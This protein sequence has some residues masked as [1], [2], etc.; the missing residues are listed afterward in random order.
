MN[1]QRAT[2]EDADA[3]TAIAFAAKRHW[4]YP[5]DWIQRWKE[6]L[7]I[8]PEFVRFHPTYVAIE[9]QRIVGFCAFQLRSDAAFLEHLWVE[10]GSIGR[11]VGRALFDC[12]EQLARNGG[13]GRIEIESD[14]NAKG[15]YEQMGATVYGAE[16]AAMEDYPR[17]LPLLRKTLR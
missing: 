1:V 12:V 13:A 5:E 8:T 16:S 9:D 15:F 4:G 7:T 2:P 6:A 3:L 10:P 17:F 14:P 11:G